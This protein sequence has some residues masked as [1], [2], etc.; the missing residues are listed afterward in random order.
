[1][2]RGRKSQGRPLPLPLLRPWLCLLMTTPFAVPLV[3][4]RRTVPAAPPLSRRPAW[5]GTVLHLGRAL[6]PVPSG[7]RL[8]PDMQREQAHPLDLQQR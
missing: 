5:L 3:P 4:T 1:M 2:K 8:T 7:P 6:W